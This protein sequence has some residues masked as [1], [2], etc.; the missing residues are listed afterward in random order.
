MNINNYSITLILLI[1]SN[2]V[3]SCMKIINSVVVVGLYYGFFTTFSIGPSYFF[4]LRA[5][6]LEV[7]DEKEISATT[8]GFIA[9]QLM[10][11]IS[12]YY[13]PLH[14]A[15]RKPHT[16]TALVLPYLL[17]HFFWNNHKNFFDSVYT[18]GNSMRNLNIQCIFLNSLIFQLF[19]HFILPSSTLARLINI[20]MFRYN[21]KMLFVASSFVGWLVGHIF[22][23]KW[24]ELV[25]FWI[26][27]NHLIRSNKYLVSELKNSMSRIFSILLF[28][29]CIYYLGRMP[30]PLV[31]KKL[32]KTSKREERGKNKEETDVEIEKISEEKGTNEQQEGSAEEDPSLCSEEKEGL[33][34]IDET[35]EI[36]VNLNGREK[37][38]DEFNKEKYSKNSPVCENYDLDGN[39]DNFELK[40]KEKEKKNIFWFEKPLVT[41]LFDYKRWNRP[42]RYIKNDFFENAVRNE[43]SQYFFYTCQS[44]GKQ[45]ISFTYLPSLST[46]LEMIQQKM[47][48]CITEKRSYEESY[49]NWVYTNDEK[50]KNLSNELFNRIAVLDKGFL[51]TDVLEK[52][53]RLCNYENEQE[54]LPKI[55]DPLLNGPYRG[56]I[57]ELYSRS[58]MNEYLIPSIEDPRDTIWINKLY[59]IFPT[60]F[61]ELKKKKIG[62]R[63]NEIK[64]KVFQWSYKLIDDLEEEEEEEETTEDRG[65]RSRKAKRVVIFNDNETT[66]NNAS[67]RDQVDEV[68]LISYSQQSDFRR[69]IIKGSMRAQR[70][71]TVTWKL[72][73]TRVHSPLFLDRIDKIF[74]LS[75]DIDRIL[76]FI[77]RN[78]MV[79]VTEFKIMDSEEQ[80]A[81]KKDKKKKENERIT[82]AETWDTVLF[83]QTIRGCIL[84]IQSILRKLIVLPSLIIAK[85]I[86]HMLV[87]K[88]TEWHED[89]E[90]LNKEIHVKCT[91]NGVQLSENEFPKNWL[92]DGIQIKILFPFCLKS[93]HRSKL[94]PE[95]SLKKKGKKQNFYFL[96]VWGMEAELPFGSPR[97]GPSFFETIWKQLKKKH[98]KV[99]VKSFV[100]VKIIKERTKWFGKVSNEK[101]KWVTKKVQFIKKIMKELTKRNSI[102]LF[103][104]KKVSE[105]NSN[106]NKTEKFSIISNK[107]IPEF[108]IRIRSIDWTNY[109]LTEKKMKDMADRINTIRNQIEKITKDKKSI[110]LTTTT[111]RNIRPNKTSWDDKRLE[112]SKI[113]WQ[114]VKRGRAK[115]IR[116]CNFFFHFCI[117][118][119]CIDIFLSIINIPSRNIQI[120]FQQKKKI[121]DK[122]SYNDETKKNPIHFISTIKR[123]IYKTTNTSNKSQI[124]CDLSFLS[125]AYVFYKLSQIQ[126]SNKYNLKSLFQ[127]H[128]T[129]PFIKDKIKI[130]F[131]TQGIFNSESR[132]KNFHD[133]GMN[134][135]QSWLMGNDQYQYNLSQTCWSGLVPQKWRNRINKNLANSSNF[136]FY[137]KEPLIHYEKE[138]NYAVNS[139]PSRREKLKNYKYDLLSNKYI[140]YENNSSSSFYGLPLEVNQAH[141][142]LYNYN[143][144]NSEVFDLS[145]DIDFRN[146]LREDYDIDRDQNSDRKYLDWRTFNFCLRKKRNIAEWTNIDIGTSTTIT[147]KIKSQIHYYQIIDKLEKNKTDN[148]GFLNLAI[149]KQIDSANQ[150]KVFF[151]WMGMNEEI[152]NWSIL[153][154]ELWFFPE[155]LLLYDA[156]KIQPWI[157]PLNLLLLKLNINEKQKGDLHISYNKNKSLDLENRNQEETQQPVRGDL[158]SY[159][160]KENNPGSDPLKK[161][162]D[163]KEDF[164]R[165]NI[166]RNINKKKS[167][168]NIAA[169]LDF[170]LKKYFL[171]QLRWDNSFSEKIIN[172]IKIYCLLLRLKN[173]KEIAISSIQRDEMSMDVMLV[174]KATTFIKLRKRRLLLIEPARLS[175]NWDGLFIMYQTLVILQVHN[176]KYQTCKKKINVDNKGL[177]ESMARHEILFRNR[178]KN[179][180]DFLIPENLLSSRR[181]RELRIQ[182]CLNLRNFKVGDRN[183]EFSNENSTRSC[184]LFFY[185]DKN[186]DVDIKKIL[187]FKFFLWPNYR[188]EDLACMNR[189][190]FDTNNGSRFSM[191]RIHMYPY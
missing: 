33:D 89:F 54:C 35:E 56:T 31:T 44:D 37:T 127:Y 172:N 70:R 117:E 132:H 40:K 181:R 58:S 48:L 131:G 164:D 104:L 9:G 186:L 184:D 115:I 53:T 10:M 106:R 17:F 27:Q 123:S 94:Q 187:K 95:D 29:V 84:V 34:K 160:Q 32:K 51:V 79:E 110:F 158:G 14:L 188:L 2:L 163:G 116:K 136:Y 108:A 170:F 145:G 165:S 30:S 49:N 5:R 42:L 100:A 177:I 21:N 146:Y 91:Y 78:W 159:V 28:I 124:L 52:R 38:K 57:K 16:I 107:M 63:I 92:T 26:R 71:K 120:L 191:S 82:I 41:L 139:L 6:V 72:F 96:T 156:Y 25:L 135:W 19:N 151:D 12:I 4:L 24:V 39:Q 118:K 174:P 85:N 162:T 73:Q 143:T 183:R 55:Y 155:F 80:K 147:K 133:F 121:N 169:E 157:I 15:L 66:K 125:Q 1:K 122:Y 50:K 68:A 8:I 171:F 23:M 101:T 134:E 105:S 87:F 88:P 74:V 114:I 93:R 47:L 112:Q 189:Y 111:D 153:N 75:F 142:I 59:D 149:Y 180:Y 175:I 176:S 69:D 60:D 103:E 62:K 102:S 43:M 138:K 161:Q 22:F 113:F 185:E 7:G 67:N 178:D 76:N 65:I 148:K 119:I 144:Y 140:N 129:I 166:Q 81:K 179:N 11:F 97:K 137:E 168:S 64:K 154:R 3:S 98:K 126:V 18:T 182:I 45:K 46:F 77:F 167:K 20:Y 61:K 90:E 109:S 150:T 99:K 86:G 130:F 128:G 152:L 36:Q 83:A 190:W 141:A 173:P 13:A